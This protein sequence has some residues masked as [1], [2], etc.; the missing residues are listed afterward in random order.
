MSETSI[1]IDHI[2][3]ELL[4]EKK[5]ATIKDILST[6]NASEVIVLFE[7]IDKKEVP[8]IFRLLPK[9][10]AAEAFM[11]MDHDFQELLI[12]SFSDSELKAVLDEL[13]ANDTADIIEEMPANV[14]ERILNQVDPAIRKDI[15][16]L[17]Q[18]PENSAGSIMT[19][20][21]VSL[22]L[23]MTVGEAINHIRNNG[24]DKKSFYACYVTKNRKLI[25]RISVKDLLLAKDDSV[26]IDDLMKTNVISVNT[27]D[28][29]EEVA[30]LLSQYN[31]YALPV[32]DRDGR[33]VG[34]ISF[35][36][37]LD[38]MEDEATEDIEI[39]GGMTPSEKTYLRSS[40]LDLFRHR[41]GWLLLLMV[42]ATF[43]GLIITNFE[44][45]LAVQ[46]VL[47]AFIPMLMDTGGNS[48][49]QSSVTI[50]RA[51][52]L[53]EIEFRD[54]PKIVFKE[55]FTAFLCGLVLS[56]ACFAKLMVIDRIILGKESVT[57]LVA[58]TVCVTMWATV[59]IAKLIGCSLP[60]CAKKLG[61]DPAVMASPFITTI[62]DAVSLLVYFGIAKA[63]LF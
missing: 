32:V 53:G 29:K 61:F 4:E 44:N 38:V 2:I 40:P 57:L 63:L 3:D 1:K 30:K 33:M 39:M 10:T 16:Q 45:A 31:Y 47:A 56:C 34:I 13:Y 51:L 46:V 25:G 21:Y 50:I 8:V 58:L 9:D 62:V 35:D 24:I 54:I 15:N 20:E 19:T 22:R 42:S 7:H 23:G 5:F 52:S 27:L 28:D 55:F 59:I 26:I 6:I 60:L 37:A 17:L 18:Y 41:I 14:V 12:K 49:S 48:G 36:D 43:T 11:E